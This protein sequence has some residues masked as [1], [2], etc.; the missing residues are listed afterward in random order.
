MAKTDAGKTNGKTSQEGLLAPLP[1]MPRSR[2]SKPPQACAC[3]C[4]GET[5][6]GKFIPGHDG[7]VKGWALRIERGVVKLKDVPDGEREAVKKFMAAQEAARG[8]APAKG[9]KGGKKTEEAVAPPVGEANND[10]DDTE[11][12]TADPGDDE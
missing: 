1:P 2:K 12:G 4:G 7:R 5:K 3:G 9:K 6:G 11:D 8:A 10:A